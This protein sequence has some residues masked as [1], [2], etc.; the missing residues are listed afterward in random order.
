MK[1]PTETKDSS[2]SS[3]TPTSQPKCPIS[4][5]EAKNGETCAYD[6]TKMS[7]WTSKPAAAKAKP[8]E[9]QVVAESESCPMRA[10]SDSTISSAQQKCPISGQEAKNGETCAY[11]PTKMSFWTSKPAAA[12]AK[13]VELQVVAESESC[14]MRAKSDTSS[15]ADKYKNPNQYNVST[16]QWTL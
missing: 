9:Q 15:S 2:S 8:V 7:F 3:T 1:T 5:Q 10:K 6:P 11:D 13:P 12:K 14:P 16:C 4:G